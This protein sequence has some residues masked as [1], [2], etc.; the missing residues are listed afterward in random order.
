MKYV[1]LVGDGMA[2]ETIQE[3]G[4][5]TPLEAAHTP[6][7]DQ[8]ALHGI[9]GELQTIPEGFSPGSDVANLTLMGYDP[10]KYYTGR[11]PFEAVS[12]GI[13]LDP[14]DVAYRCNLVTLEV[15]GLAI[16]MRD[17]TAGHISSDDAKV[18]IDGLNAQMSKEPVSFFPGVSYRHLM[19]WKSGS[20]DVTLTPPHDILEQSIEDYLPSGPASQKII[21]WTTTAQIYLKSH[22]LNQARMAR[23]ENPANSIWLWGQGK[24]PTIPT[25]QERYHLSGGVVTAVDLIKGIGLLSGLEAPDVPGATGYLDTDYAAKVSTALKIL[26][27]G[28]FAFI[29]VE[30]PDEAGHSGILKDKIRAIEDFDRYIVG[31]IYAALQ[32]MGQDFRLLILPDHPTPLSIRTHTSDPVPFLAYDSGGRFK[33]LIAQPNPFSETSASE[34]PLKIRRGHLLMQRWLQG[35]LNPGVIQ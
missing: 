23:G 24:K 16:Y 18:L 22:P 19:V 34:S 35:N 26:E 10:R 6:N 20:A 8:I 7:I 33:N 3:L 9:I 12:M 28:D 21:R 13:P 25:F 5:K 32:K 2:D 27:T 29:H 17:F 14:E 31:P 1:V 11:A 30:A 4:G 15:L